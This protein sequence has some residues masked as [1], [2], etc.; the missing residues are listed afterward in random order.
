M[1]R[2]SY[3]MT[4]K[5]LAAAFLVGVGC[6][7][8]PLDTGA[9][10]QTLHPPLS[11][12]KSQT[13]NQQAIDDTHCTDDAMLVFD[14]STSMGNPGYREKI[15]RLTEA[16]KAMSRVLPE[17][18]QFRKLGLIVFGPGPKDS[19][20]NIDYR[21]APALRN[22]GPIMGELD[23][24]EPA[25]RTPLTDAVGQAASLL[26]YT[27]KPAVVV[28]VTDGDDT[29][30]GDPC[31]L[32]LDLLK[33]AKAI[34]IHVIGFKGR[35]RYYKFPTRQTG[36]AVYSQARCL[37]ETTG[38]KFITAETSDE[39]AAALKQTLGCPFVM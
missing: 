1:E 14:G 15:P 37:A 10:A 20:Q 22:A 13:I 28:L 31:A 5:T 7:I 12:P 26:N 27:K 29:C 17:I 25:G 23:R 4:L 24:L 36:M 16:R 3:A 8:S 32:A 6:F 39:L 38:G 2:E 9:R 11:D 35:Y 30:R 21:V 33:D 34:T 18:T 19:C